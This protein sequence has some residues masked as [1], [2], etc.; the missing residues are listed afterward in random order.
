MRIPLLTVSLVNLLVETKE[1][2]TR[3]EVNGFYLK[4]SQGKLRG[5]ISVSKEELV[6]NDYKGSPYSSIID[7]FLTQVSGGN[8]MNIYAWYDNEWGYATRLVDMVEFV[9]KKG[10]LL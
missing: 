7:P 9:A 8:L 10:G 1:K 5:I 4:A 3:E 6:S 2:A